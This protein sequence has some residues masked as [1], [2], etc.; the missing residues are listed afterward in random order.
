MF[1][2]GDTG[3]TFKYPQT[4]GTKDIKPVDWPPRIQITSGPFACTE[5]GSE[6]A[7]AGKTA[8]HTV[9][10]KSYCV[11]KI[12][13]GAAGSIYTQ[14]AYAFSK[15]S[16]V[17]VFTFSLKYT[18]CDVYDSAKRKSCQDENASFNPDPIIDAMA[19]TIVFKASK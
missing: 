3:T 18:N 11:T 13:E 16:K 6:T 12:T 7:R 2:D 9:N 17:P 5:A 8:L 4:I 19:E 15:D 14:F 10:G 1:V